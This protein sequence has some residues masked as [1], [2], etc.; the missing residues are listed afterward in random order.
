NESIASWTWDFGD[1]SAPVTIIAPA[2]PNISHIFLGSAQSHT[3][4]LTVTLTSGCSAFVEHVVSSAPAPV[5]DFSFPN[6]N[7][8]MVPV[9]FTDESQATG[10][11]LINQ[12]NW[13]F[14]DPASGTGNVSTLTNPT[15]QFSAPGS[16]TVREVVIN[17]I[18]C[19]DT[20]FKT[21]IVGTPP[22]P[23]FIADTAC[24]GYPTSFTD[25]TING[26]GAA[27]QY[28][29]NFGDGQTSTLVNPSHTYAIC[30]TY[31]VHLSV[32]SSPGCIGDTIK[33]VKVLCSPVALFS[34]NTPNC[35]GDTVH[36]T[37]L[38]T[39]P[40]GYI[41]KWTWN[42]GDGS[43][44]SINFPGNPSVSHAYS[45]PG[46]YIVTLTIHTSDSCISTKQLPVP[47]SALPI[48]NFITGPSACEFIPMQFTDISQS[49][50]GGIINQWLWN[51]GDPGSGTNNTSTLQNPTH[52]FTHSGSF[53][54]HL[55]VTNINGCSSTI[56]KNV[57]VNQS[58]Q[59]NFSADTACSENPTQFTDQSIANFGTVVAWLW[60]F[61]DPSS[62]TNNISTLQNPLHTYSTPGNYMVTL[63]ITNSG[64][65]V[66]DTLI[67]VSVSAKPEALFSF[68]PTCVKDSTQFTDLSVAPN[69]QI[70][71]WL[72]NF[73]DGTPPAT[74]QNPKHAYQVAG[75]YNVTLTV[76]NLGGCKDSIS[77]AVVARPTPTAAYTYNSLFCPG[78]TVQF[79]DQSTGQG[80][81]IVDR[82][83]TF[84]PGYHSNAPDPTYVFSVTDTTYVVSLEVTDN[85]GCKDTIFDS[86]Y[87]KPAFAFTFNNDTACYLN[88]T[89]FTPQDLTPGD[90][91]FYITWDFGDPAS[92]SS[93][94]SHIYHAV[95]TFTH[96]GT[97]TVKMTATDWDNCKDSVYKV[98]VVRGLPIAQFAASTQPC[99][100][101]VYFT[102][103]SS[104]GGG[105]ILKWE[106]N[107]GDGTPPVVI[108]APGPGN[109][110]HTY[111]VPGNYL[112][113][114][115]VTNANGC[116]DTVSQPVQ[117]VSCLS[118]SFSK[119]QLSCA[120]T[121][122]M[123][124]DSSRPSGSISS[125]Y[126]KWGDGTDTLYT[127]FAPTIHHTYAN[128]GNYSVTLIIQAMINS[129]AFA[130]SST[131]AVI[132]HPT[133]EAF[134]SN[135]LVCMHTAT[136]FHDTSWTYGEPITVWNWNFGEPV[137]GS[138][139][140]STLKNPT[141]QYDTSG[142]YPVHLVVMNEFGCKDSLV[143]ITRVYGIP[144][145]DFSNSPACSAHPIYFN[146]ISKLA[147][148][149]MS[150]WMWNFGDKG[151]GQNISLQ[152]DPTHQY[153]REG[154]YLVK[155]QV[156]DYNGCSDSCDS[157]IHVNPSP[158]AAFTLTDDLNGRPGKIQLNNQSLGATTFDWDFG[159]GQTSTEENPVVTYSEDGTYIIRL[160]TDNQYSCTDTTYYKYEMLFKGLFIPNAFSPESPYEGV[161]LF[162]PVGVNLKEYHIQV[163][164]NWGHLLWESDKLDL[165]GRP[166]EGWDGTYKGQPMPEGTYAWKVVAVFSDDTIWQGSDNGKSEP[167]TIGTVT[168]IR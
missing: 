3:V 82:W 7:C 29:W 22:T 39:T 141:H 116:E 59:A 115:T 118:A 94:I 128:A 58:P 53:Q 63:A 2:S 48:A 1:G 122:V 75:T 37:D 156:R 130:D 111:A 40:Q 140:V 149:L 152:K 21:I 147:D 62:G 144:K 8:S 105:T 165:Y 135:N 64:G 15:H 110:T 124:A 44:L 11:Y 13:N 20:I 160:I 66:D 114:L 137:S 121:E 45:A 143:K 10:G 17:I 112:V 92:G 6:S 157:T 107:F 148:T 83:W 68:T 90:S 134:F 85:Y 119:D 132:V 67:M 33:M 4:R 27:L 96:A 30:G 127:T 80:S 34:T 154:D 55:T 113:I 79:Q 117:Q 28:L 151:S 65:C 60:H 16:Y 73:G 104:A 74:I 36:F 9:P 69:S 126:W 5:A 51:F 19:S 123:F 24:V 86:V 153:L 87:V 164:D 150:Y 70:V 108:N 93:N 14:G 159:N 97:F 139:N 31:T 95:H 78:G 98:V 158:T 61:G 54:V 72:W 42:F 50:G 23:N 25:Q 91:L 129:V 101:I 131:Q 99:D 136:I 120:R 109:T 138:A 76:T 41:V 166:A 133:P 32:S 43:G 161:R 163:W 26:S 84:E 145:A 77:Q 100:T 167:S 18:G 88:P 38:S 49:N 155:L 102:D 52:S 103:L 12:W 162:K 106:W 56:T 146:D 168:L 81:V 89:H 46:L 142:S 35:V 47:V 71:G 57:S 125:W